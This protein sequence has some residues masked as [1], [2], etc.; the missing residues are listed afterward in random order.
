MIGAFKSRAAPFN[1]N[2]RYV[3]AELEYLFRDSSARAIIYHASF[4]PRLARLL[5]KL[6]SVSLLLQVDDGSGGA[7]PRPRLREGAGRDR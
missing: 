1:V 5:P 2:Y 6:P 4:A 7:S 3:D